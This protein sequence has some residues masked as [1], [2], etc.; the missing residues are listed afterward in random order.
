M[1]GLKAV[2]LAALVLA[3]A[4]ARQD[5]G[6]P[7]SIGA[8]RFYSPASATTTIEGVCEVRLP[9]LMRGVGQTARYRIDVAVL[10]SAGLELQHSDWS[11]EV[12]AVVAHSR[13]ATVVESFGF[14]AAPGRYRVRV[15]VTP[16]TGDALEREAVVEAFAAPPAIS[17]L[18][19][20]TSARQPAS[21]SEALGAGEV[22]RGGLVL[23]TGPSP[24]L[25]PTE[26]S[27]IWYA[28]LYP[29]GTAIAG[30]MRAEVLGA[31]GRR[32]TGTAPAPVRVDATGGMTR[33]SLDLTGLPEGSYTFRLSLQLS[34]TT[35]VREAPF[36]MAS[37]ATLAAAA[38]AQPEQPAGGGD[39]FDEADEARLDSL[40]APLVYLASNMRDLNLYRG[41][42]LDGKRRFMKQFW[43]ERDPTPATSDNPARE[44]FYRGVAYANSAFRESGAA[45][46]P[47]WNSDRGRIYLKNGRPDEVLQRPAGSPRPYEAWKYTRDRNR[48]YVF[49]DQTG[50]GHYLLLGTNDN[51][52]PSRQQ[53]QRTLGGDG[54]RDVYNFL[55]LDLRSLQDLDINP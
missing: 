49:M 30:Q 14:S 17:D 12:P 39:M 16:Q 5:S 19:L 1:T 21:D 18:M 32:I 53:W 28:E 20:A 3:A 41:L 43:A 45:E 48:W 47:G 6:E 54:T 8:F 52:E 55:N 44:A 15:R 37:I 2:G 25:S 34:D 22:R 10:D 13:G 42:S 33:G 23:R 29:R 40:F 27:L 35:L 24:R 38:P 50:I 51:R 26:A 31:G 7:L 11:R 46:T 36:S 9:T 4:P